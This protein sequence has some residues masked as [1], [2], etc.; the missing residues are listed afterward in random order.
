MDRFLGSGY[1]CSDFISKKRVGATGKTALSMS[2]GKRIGIVGER[3]L[4]LD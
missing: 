2:V 3:V 4:Q 1:D